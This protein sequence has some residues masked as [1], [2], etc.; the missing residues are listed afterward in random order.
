MRSDY[1]KN[2][3]IIIWLY[4]ALEDE[5]AILFN[6]HRIIAVEMRERSLQIYASPRGILNM[7]GECNI[8]VRYRKSK[9]NAGII[10]KITLRTYDASCILL[11]RPRP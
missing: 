1:K 11:A 5:A 6:T 4:N 9:R 8:A 10:G 3:T 7:P 2:E